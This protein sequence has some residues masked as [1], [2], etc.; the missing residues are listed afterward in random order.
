MRCWEGWS[1]RFGL[2]GWRRERES[3][4]FLGQR[5]Q[6]GLEVLQ[7]P[8]VKRQIQPTR[9]GSDHTVHD[10]HGMAQPQPEGLTDGP[11]EVSRLQVDP[12]EMTQELDRS[13]LSP[14]V[15]R[16][17]ND[18]QPDD[19]DDTQ[20]RLPGEPVPGGFVRTEEVDE[21]SR[22]EKAGHHE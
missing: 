22:V 3:V 16:A 9:G 20:T 18:L 1:G 2:G 13:F 14:K 15:L 10:I 6:H 4:A 11:I 5:T 21:N 19:G 8:G 12:L 7:V 17:L